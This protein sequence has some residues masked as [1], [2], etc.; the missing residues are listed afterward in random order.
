MA[1]ATKLQEQW[2]AMESAAAGC[3]GAE[4]VPGRGHVPEEEELHEM[5]DVTAETA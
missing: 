1:R 4:E 2:D 5:F 3:G